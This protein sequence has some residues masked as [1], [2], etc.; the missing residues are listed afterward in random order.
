MYPDSYVT[1]K[2]H[3]RADLRHAM[4]AGR[5]RALRRRPQAG[6]S[7][8]R[9]RGELAA[10]LIRFGGAELGVQGEC[11]LPVVVGLFILAGAVVAFGQV[12]VHARLLVEVARFGC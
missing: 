5:M 1:V 10:D 2:V 8:G 11:L 6:W 7:A 3:K 12:T 9:C 4:P